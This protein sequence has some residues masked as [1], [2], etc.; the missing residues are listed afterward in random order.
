MLDFE[1][2]DQPTNSWH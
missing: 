1:Q 2:L